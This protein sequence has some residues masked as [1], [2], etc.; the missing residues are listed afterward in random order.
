LQKQIGTGSFSTGGL[1]SIEEFVCLVKHAPVI[2]SVNT[3][4]VHIAASVGTPVVVLYAQTNPQHTPWGV[5][6]KVLE[7]AVPAYL[8]SKNEVIAYVNKTC[9]CVPMNAN[10]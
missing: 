6:N 9:I 3:G 2:I 1:F 10:C 8:R 5:P 4:T 7:F